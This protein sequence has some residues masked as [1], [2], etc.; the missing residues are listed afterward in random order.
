MS[1]YKQS[2]D[3]ATFRKPEDIQKNSQRNTIQLLAKEAIKGSGLLHYYYVYTDNS[4]KQTYLSAYPQNTNPPWGK[5]V[6]KTGT[7]SRGT[8]D[9]KDSVL[10]G[11]ISGNAND[12]AQTFQSLKTEFSRV[13][14]AQIDYNSF[15][16]GLTNSNSVA[17]TAL[18]NCV[19]NSQV[20]MKDDEG[21][22]SDSSLDDR[23]PGQSTQIL[24]PAKSKDQESKSTQENN[25]STTEQH[26]SIL[27]MYSADGTATGK[28]SVSK[29]IQELQTANYSKEDITA[30]LS[31]MY[32]MQNVP[33]AQRLQL[34]MEE[35]DRV[36][37]T[38][39]ATLSA[40]SQNTL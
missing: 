15:R 25:P 30:V 22:R 6:T 20:Q 37:Q 21:P 3:T 12:V 29:M 39:A 13:E 24:Q 34:A 16:N 36:N 4:G 35:I 32:E 9:F 18:Y 19:S 31:T 14:N 11:T 7:Y 1:T 26:K 38:M 17:T 27:A 8:P 23:A 5:L 33:E 28:I 10:I 2:T 40:S